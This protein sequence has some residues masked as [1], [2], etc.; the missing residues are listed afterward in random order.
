MSGREYESARRAGYFGEQQRDGRD[1]AA[2]SGSRP[3]QYSSSARGSKALTFY[4]ACEWRDLNPDI[5]E[6][7]ERIALDEAAHER[8][9]SMQLLVEQTRKQDR[10]NRNGEP[11][12]LN[13]SHCP[14][15]ARMLATEHPEIRPYIEL[16]GSEWDI[17]FPEA[18]GC[19]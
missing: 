1:S 4:R 3:R 10:V 6:R 15:W 18:R 7:W 13:N 17:D 8:R 16:R 9:F 12:K 14:I 2:I 19:A 5:W 11:V